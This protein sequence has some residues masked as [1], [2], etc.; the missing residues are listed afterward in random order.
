[1]T[2]TA[3]DLLTEELCTPNCL[4][5]LSDEADKCACRCKG[6][7]HA[8][9][10]DTAIGAKA[11]GESTIGSI[12]SGDVV[13][14]G[15]TTGG[16]PVGLVES[17]DRLGVRLALMSFLTGCFEEPRFIPWARMDE[18]RFAVEE[19][20]SEAIATARAFGGTGKVFDTKPLGDFQNFW[21]FRSGCAPCIH[22]KTLLNGGKLFFQLRD[23]L[24]CV[25]C[26]DKR[27]LYEEV[28]PTDSRFRQRK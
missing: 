6:E 25:T 12:R 2:A 10:V 14:I 16:C 8:M 3:R 24:A 27:D 21:L 15:L 28:V 9:L 13:A 7:F 1:M 4:L 11:Q 20:D 5:A 19:T 18:V 23:G 17:V 26:V 22:C